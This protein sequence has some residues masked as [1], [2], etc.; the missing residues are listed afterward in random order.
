MNQLLRLL[1]VFCVL[2]SNASRADDLTLDR[3]GYI[4]DWVMLAPIALRE[5]EPGADAIFREQIR[6]EAALRPKAGDTVK[7]GGREL[8]WQNITASTNY[9]DLNGILK[10]LN[11][12]AA[13]YMATYIECETERPR[14]EPFDFSDP[15]KNISNTFNWFSGFIPSPLSSTIISAVPLTLFAIIFI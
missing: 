3:A 12:R 8:T 11:D 10:S 1:G 9:F 4:R 5:G 15:L 14:P 13:G 2:I 6:S 7:V